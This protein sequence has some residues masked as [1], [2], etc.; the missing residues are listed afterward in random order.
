MS[1]S[2]VLGNREYFPGIGK[3]Q[4]EGAGSD[5]PLAFKYYDENRVVAGKTMKEHFRFA[6]A[7]WHTF[8]GTGGD[9][10]GPGTKKFPWLEASDAVQS[11]KDKMDAAFEFFTKIG[12]PYFCFHDVD[13][14]DEGPSLAE[15]ERRLS[16]IV[17]YAK[18][19]IAASGVKVL[20]KFWMRLSYRLSSTGG[21]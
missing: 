10:F 20:W 18:E 4:F 5:N 11:A 14:V 19:K 13:L 2:V 9:P 7:Y 15:S 21:T 3:I 6:T 17:D 12:T 16:A 1:N 8:C